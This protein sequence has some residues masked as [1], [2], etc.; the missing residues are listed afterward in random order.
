MMKMKKILYIQPLIPS[1][2]NEVVDSLRINFDVTVM[3]SKEL[4]NKGGFELNNSHN[5]IIQ[6]APIISIFGGKLVYQ[7]GILKKI[8]E[9][10]PD[11]ILACGGPRDISYL[12]LLVACRL[13]SIKVYSHSQGLYKKDR[14]GFFIKK[15]YR[16]LVVFSDYFICYAPICEKAMLDIG[17]NKE[18]LV[19][20]K[21]SLK[22][23]KT[24]FPQEKEGNKGVMFI[25]RLREETGLED[26]IRAISILEDEGQNI[27]L[28]VVGGG[29]MYN[30]FFEK[31]N[32][33][34]NIFWYGSL[35]D[36]EKMAQISKKCDVGCYPGNAGLS[37]VHMFGLS[38]P[39]IT[40]S[41]L[42]E[43]MGPEPSYIESGKNGLFYDRDKKGLVGTL[44]DYFNL[45][46][47][48]KFNL[49]K[50]AFDTYQNLNCPS[51]GER[52]SNFI[53]NTI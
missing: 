33:K 30:Y 34:N 3:A 42:R 7:K 50:G 37:V 49:R 23:T 48:D 20:M 11:A 19:T 25:G 15:I 16:F 29:E 35:H 47:H 1:Y 8:L 21:N 28:H 52:L 27:N 38:L 14:P 39:V 31:Y 5:L 41:R 4:S 26:L 53:K 10:R 24:V 32:N 18:K 45:S 40:H 43:H 22:I 17:V 2:R 6:D 13:L 36:H 46:D 9:D 12:I 44:R 51:L